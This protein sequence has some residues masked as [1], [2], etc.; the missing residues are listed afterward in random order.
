M[1][2]KLASVLD[3]DTR[4]E[5]EPQR[6]GT[7]KEKEKKKNKLEVCLINFFFF[8]TQVGGEQYNLDVTQWSRCLLLTFIIKG[9]IT[10]LLF[11]I[12]SFVLLH[13]SLVY[14][15]IYTHTLLHCLLSPMCFHILHYIYLSLSLSLARSHTI[16][17]SKEVSAFLYST[18]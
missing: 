7:Q 3:L 12:I 11:I 4:A 16:M 6:R 5:A 17:D 8:F 18:R 15:S 9:Q 10:F 13:P 14:H 1:K 2:W